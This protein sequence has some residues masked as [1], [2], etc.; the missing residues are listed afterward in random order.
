MFVTIP[1]WSP[2]M[3]A[4]EVQPSRIGSN[5]PMSLG[6]G[7][8]VGARRLGLQLDEPVWPGVKLGGDRLE[9]GSRGAQR[10]AGPFR[11]VAIVGGRVAREV[12]AGELGERTVTVD[13]RSRSEPV[14]GVGIGLLAAGH[15]AAQRD[16]AEAGEQEEVDQR[17]PLGAD[18]G[19][20]DA[21][22]EL[23]YG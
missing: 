21:L 9:T 18:A 1:V 3:S 5:W 2:T 23:A 7:S 13:G 10:N 16:P 22:A 6:G 20:C 17:L 12:S 8:G 19:R 14:L 4:R 11:E 15:R